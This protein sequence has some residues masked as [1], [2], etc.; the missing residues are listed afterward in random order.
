MISSADF[1]LAVTVIL[2]KFLEEER[3]EEIF[4]SISSNMFLRLVISPKSDF[5]INLNLYKEGQT[6]E[7]ES[8]F[9]NLL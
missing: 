3:L 5:K 1:I 4:A 7:S 9:S 6:E 2:V 8:C